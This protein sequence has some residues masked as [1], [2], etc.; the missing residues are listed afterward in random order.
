MVL[1]SFR[2]GAAALAVLGLF[3]QVVNPGGGGGAST[4]ATSSLLA[5]TGTANGVQAATQAQ[6]NAYLTNA[7]PITTSGL[8]VLGPGPMILAP[9]T[10]NL[11]GDALDVYIDSAQTGKI[12]SISSIGVGFF[13]NG[14]TVNGPASVANLSAPLIIPTGGGPTM[15]PGAAAGTSPTCTTVAGHNQ[16]FV[17]SCTTG[18]A[19]TTGTLAT[20]TFSSALSAAPAG[21]QLTPR[22][23]ISAP[24]MT[25]VY[26]TAPSTTTFT[27]AVSTA[28]TASTAYSWSVICL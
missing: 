2:A 24:A 7:G 15:A 21:C 22:N 17:V 3:P 18:T 5:G 8:N 4:P 9:A 12:A 19:T 23:A 28:L 16:S 27:L 14:L 6:V 1:Q 25:S 13:A 11:A 10:G 26:T 20:V